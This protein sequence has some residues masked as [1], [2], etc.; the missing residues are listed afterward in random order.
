MAF[1]RPAAAI[2]LG[3]RP[4]QCLRLRSVFYDDDR[5][6]ARGLLPVTPRLIS[7]STFA[8]RRREDRPVIGGTARP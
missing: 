1:D 6:K 5:S 8:Q 2:P 4:P 7:L 3:G